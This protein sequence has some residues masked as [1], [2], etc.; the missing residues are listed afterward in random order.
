MAAT[1][2]V[3]ML[4]VARGF[5]RR[6]KTVFRGNTNQLAK[7]STI[8]NLRLERIQNDNDIIASAGDLYKV[9]PLAGTLVT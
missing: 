7:K 2:S 4:M 3:K 8:A 9:V 5:K 6:I 1:S